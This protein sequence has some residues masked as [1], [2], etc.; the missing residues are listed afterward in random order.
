[1]IWTRWAIGVSAGVVLA[2]TY[3]LLW[4]FVGPAWAA[5]LALMDSRSSEV[6]REA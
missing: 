5:L 6:R 4:F 1:M 2:Q 3:G